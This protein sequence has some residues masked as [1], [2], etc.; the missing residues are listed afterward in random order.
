MFGC[1]QDPVCPPS[2]VAPPS[3]AAAGLVD[4]IPETFDDAFCLLAAV[5]PPCGFAVGLADAVSE[6]FDD[7]L[8]AIAAVAPHCGFA[9]GLI[10]TLLELLEEE[11]PLVNGSPNSAAALGLGW[12]AATFRS[13]QSSA[14]IFQQFTHCSAPLDST[15]SATLSIAV[16]IYKQTVD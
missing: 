3:G 14:Q 16:A 11:A 13:L 4:A 5:A 10:D 1:R 15:L 2:V 7:G 12:A 9:T 8:S 6:Q